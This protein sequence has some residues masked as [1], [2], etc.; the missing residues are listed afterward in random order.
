VSW[1]EFTALQAEV[2]RLAAGMAALQLAFAA[3]AARL[4]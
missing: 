3:E 2:Q 4:P 1:Q